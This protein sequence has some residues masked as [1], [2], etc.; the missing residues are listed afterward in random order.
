MVYADTVEDEQELEEGAT[1]TEGD[2]AAEESKE[3]SSGETEA[4]R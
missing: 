2:R 3:E 4:Q 1:A